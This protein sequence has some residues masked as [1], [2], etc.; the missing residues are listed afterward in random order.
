MS[1]S[2]GHRKSRKHLD[3]R[4]FITQSQSFPPDAAGSMAEGKV[5]SWY[6]VTLE[7]PYLV[8]VFFAFVCT[9]SQGQ[10]AAFQPLTLLFLE[11]VCEGVDTWMGCQPAS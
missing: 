5:N 8:T 3:L 11:I 2:S 9:Q 7:V 6:Q 10:E 1:I 4:F